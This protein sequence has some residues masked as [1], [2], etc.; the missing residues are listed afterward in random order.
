[1]DELIKLV[2]GVSWIV[3]VVTLFVSPIFGV[4]ILGVAV[5]ATIASVTRTRERR[6]QELLDAARQRPEDPPINQ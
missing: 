1:M 4:I 2:G 3:G 5:L 6:H